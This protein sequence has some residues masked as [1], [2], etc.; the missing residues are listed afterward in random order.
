M[1]NIN[2]R[3]GFHATL[4]IVIICVVVLTGAIGF[5]FWNSMYGNNSSK[6]YTPN[7]TQTELK[8]YAADSSKFGF[9]FGFKYPI[10]WAVT[11]YT[12]S[13]YD[14]QDQNKFGIIVKDPN[15]KLTVSYNFVYNNGIGGH[16]SPL[17]EEI[18]SRGTVKSFNT[19]GSVYNLGYSEV[20]IS[21]IIFTKNDT[22]T[23]V[24]TYM[25]SKTKEA[26]EIKLGSDF[27]YMSFDGIISL[28]PETF[29]PMFLGSKD[30][31][32]KILINAK[33]M[34]SGIKLNDLYDKDLIKPN[35]KVSDVENARNSTEYKQAVDILLST[36]YSKL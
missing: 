18:S 1:K 34:G 15:N 3:P 22:V 8:T 35:L 32:D 11:E 26:P 23:Y 16:C 4:M 33:I 24:S 31:D 30:P 19:K 28:Y 13:Y 6:T 36:T 17:D 25:R 9:N 20:N 2:N 14:S 10:G 5:I 27:C 29:R 12:G 7:N 21:E